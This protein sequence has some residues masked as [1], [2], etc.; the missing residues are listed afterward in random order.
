M[1]MK[2]RKTA[3]KSILS[4]YL[5]YDPEAES[6][7]VQSDL[8]H[9]L[10][11]RIAS[12]DYELSPGGQIVLS[13]NVNVLKGII[14]R[15]RGWAKTILNKIYRVRMT[16]ESILEILKERGLSSGWSVGNLYKG[17]YYDRRSNNSYNE[18]S[19]TID[20]KGLDMDIIRSIAKALGKKFNQN[21]VMIV[22]NSSGVAKIIKTGA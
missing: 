8:T 22:D 13:T 15:M 1:E 11:S 12:D 18:K 16:D 2:K 4:F 14:G 6:F 21:E 5:S 20:I 10:S 9:R 7:Y 19:F 17:R 3:D